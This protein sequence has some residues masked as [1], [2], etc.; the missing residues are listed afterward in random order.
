MTAIQ[1]T[2]VKARLRLLMQRGLRLTGWGV[3][4]MA[5][6]AAVALVVAQALGVV[7]PGVWY[8]W[9]AG[10]VL[11]VALVLGALVAWWGRPGDDTV[12]V[13]VDE[14][15]GLKD[16]LGTGRFAASLEADGRGGAVAQHVHDDAEAVAGGVTKVSLRRAFPVAPTRVWGWALGVVTVV[17]V[18]TLDPMGLVERATNRNADAAVAQATAE[19]AR[20][21]LEEAQ[22]AAAQLA[23]AEE[24]ET[25][26]GGD[27]PEAL[28]PEALSDR[29]T[30]ML[31]QRDLTNPEDRRA[32]AAEVSDLRDLAAQQA[33]RREKEVQ[34]LEN[35]MSGVDAGEPGPASDFAEAMRRSDFEQARQ[36]LTKLGD[37]LENGT[38]SEAQQQRMAEQLSAMADQLQQRADQ[39]Q[40]QADA[41]KQAAEQAMRDAGLSEEQVEQLADK[42]QDPEAIKQELAKWPS[43]WSG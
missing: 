27:L 26:K 32:A 22:Q 10:G 36:E 8:G 3:L 19:A 12:A 9:A 41:A 2:L 28:D 42:A 16:A 39:Q 31:S 20:D 40:Q 29:L 18:L 14:L 17:A 1:R 33:E 37:A 21:A 25:P 38:L 15:L 13:R 11:A 23:E 6:L 35:L 24:P 43:S 4:V 30:A 34:A 7:V 5:G